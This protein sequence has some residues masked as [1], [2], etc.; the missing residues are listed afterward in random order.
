MTG[1]QVALVVLWICAIVQIWA[2]NR[3]FKYLKDARESR[4]QAIHNLSESEIALMEAKATK[5]A[6]T[7]W[8]ESVKSFKTYS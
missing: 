6:W 4:I 7:T 2:T 1:E 3:A 8:W 5:E